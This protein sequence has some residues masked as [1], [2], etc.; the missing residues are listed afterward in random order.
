MTLIHKAL[1]LGKWAYLNHLGWHT[2][3]KLV[4]FESDDWGS[5]RTPSRAVLNHLTACGDSAARN[6]FIAHDSLERKEDLERLFSALDRFRDKN[7]APP[8]MTANFAVANPDFERIKPNEGI[9]HYEPFYQTYERLYGADNGILELLRQAE[10]AGLCKPQLHA[11]EHLNVARWM[12]SLR[13][14]E[15]DT[16]L[17]FQNCMIDVGAS[18]TPR[19]RY[20]YMDALNTDNPAELSDLKE[21][22]TDAARIF[23]E[24][25]GYRSKTFVASCFVWR[26]EIEPVLTRLGIEAI[27]TDFYQLICY[28]KGTTGLQ[29]RPHYTGQRSRSGLIYMVRTCEYEPAYG[30]SIEQSVD[31]CLDQIGNAFSAGKPAI[32]D[33][34]RFNYIGTLDP[35]GAAQRLMGLHELLAKLLKL[36]PDAEFISAD[37]LSDLMAKT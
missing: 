16:M 1:S 5:I 28:G 7:G 24:A 15:T 34:H 27:Q 31:R 12:R 29:K 26:P 37:K 19:Q 35:Q 32:V 25:F 36:Y 13:S 14:G 21:I 20:G 9:Y 18:Y 33:T 22:L 3:R 30:R 11:R 17:A 4:L 2:S 10:A 8:C 6:A 23:E